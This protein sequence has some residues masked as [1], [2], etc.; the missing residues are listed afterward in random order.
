MDLVT[1]LRNDNLDTVV[2]QF[3]VQPIRALS[4]SVVNTVLNC[5]KKGESKGSLS[6]ADI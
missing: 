1:P 2:Q 6:P 3:K 4:Q 5:S